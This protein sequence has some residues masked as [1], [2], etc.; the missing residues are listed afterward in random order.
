MI[1]LVIGA[2]AVWVGLIQLIRF[3]AKQGNREEWDKDHLPGDW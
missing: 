1:F 3:D 2:V